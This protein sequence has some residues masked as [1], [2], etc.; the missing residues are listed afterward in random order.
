MRARRGLLTRWEVA[1]LVLV[2]AAVAAYVVPIAQ[3]ATWRTRRAE[4]GMVLDSLQSAEIAWRGGHGSWF[5]LTATPRG[6]DHVG[7]DVVGWPAELPGGW[8][9][10][11]DKARGSYHTEPGEGGGVVIVGTCDVDGDGVRAVYRAVPGGPIVRVTP[12]DVY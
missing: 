6:A 7:G 4:V 12:E 10:P 8:Q 2:A 9:P 1:V 3:R 5:T 11:I